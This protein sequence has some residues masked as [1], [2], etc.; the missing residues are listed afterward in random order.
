[1]VQKYAEHILAGTNR[2]IVSL[3]KS[4]PHVD[5]SLRLDLEESLVGLVR[6]QKHL[7]QYT[8]KEYKTK[9]TKKIMVD[10]TGWK[11]VRGI[12]GAQEKLDS[13][14]GPISVVLNFKSHR[15]AFK[16]YWKPGSL[17]YRVDVDYGAATTVESFEEG[18]YEILST[19]RHEAQHVGQDALRIIKDLRELGGLPRQRDP[20]ANPYGTRGDGKS[21]EHAL[22]DIEFHTRLQDE[23]TDA[24]KNLRNIQKQDRRAML[25]LWVSE[26]PLD[27]ALASKYNVVEAKDFFV[28]LRKSA[29][30]KWRNA[31]KTYFFEVSK[32]IPIS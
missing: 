28:R 10:L 12:G 3:N 13:V 14:W 25:R 30:A 29:P 31:V 15:G 11:Y 2:L 18:K 24:V 16:G 1:M 26:G 21:T 20:D 4:I 8:A 32:R 19:I 7:G 23:I 27:P 9:V 17:E 22:R 6:L 5:D